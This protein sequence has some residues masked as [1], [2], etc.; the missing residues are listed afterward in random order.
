MYI[1]PLL[2]SKKALDVPECFRVCLSRDL[3]L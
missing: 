3:G 2:F 1:I